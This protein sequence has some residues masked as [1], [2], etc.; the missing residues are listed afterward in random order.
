MSRH[1]S[2]KALL[3]ALLFVACASPPVPAASRALPVTEEPPAELV[4]SDGDGGG[5][6]PELST[7][8]F[9]AQCSDG[10]VAMLCSKADPSRKRCACQRGGRFFW[11]PGYYCNGRLTCV[12]WACG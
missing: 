8:Q 1:R 9:R 5:C 10:S 7:L 4:S 2:L 6:G 12:S 3:G 11:S